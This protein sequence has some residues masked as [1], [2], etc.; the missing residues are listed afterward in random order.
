MVQVLDFPLPQL[1]GEL[2]FFFGE[3]FLEP[4]VEQVIVTVVPVR[5]APREALVVEE[6]VEAPKWGARHQCWVCVDCV[7]IDDVDVEGDS[8]VGQGSWESMV[9]GQMETSKKVRRTARSVGPS[10]ASSSSANMMAW[11]VPED[12]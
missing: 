1:G 3:P 11:F 12:E 8:V 2:A 9:Q 10:S 6:L 7:T 5:S 4:V